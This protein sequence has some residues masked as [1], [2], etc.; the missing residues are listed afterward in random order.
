MKV[1]FLTHLLY[2]FCLYALNVFQKRHSPVPHM[3]FS[4]S[5]PVAGLQN[6]LCQTA[7]SSPDS[8]NT[9]TAVM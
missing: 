1:C 2:Y 3:F 4:Y 9:I 6:F 8:T 5:L 7:N